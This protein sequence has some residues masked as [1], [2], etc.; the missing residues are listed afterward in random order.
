MIRQFLTALCLLG[1]LGGCGDA[2]RKMF[3]AS[4][5]ALAGEPMPEG[6]MRAADEKAEAPAAPPMAGAAPK[7][8]PAD[9]QAADADATLQPLR[10]MRMNT[11]QIIKGTSGEQSKAAPTRSWFPESFLFDPL[12]VTD[13]QGQATLDV[14]VPDRLTSWRI[15]ALAHSK[16]GSQAGATVSF[17][18]TL[19]AYVD[20]VVPPFLIAGDAVRLPIQL[21]NTTASAVSLPLQVDA[22]G[23]LLSGANGKVTVPASGSRVE[24]AELHASAPGEI[25]L[26]ASFGDADAIS[27]TIPV[28][29][30]GSP[31]SQLRGGTLAAARTL[32]IS[33][34]PDLLPGTAKVRLLVFPGALGVLRSELSS[35][36]S[37]GGSASDAY[38]LL[39]AGRAPQL[40]SALGDS[41]D[42]EAIRNLSIVASQRVL[43]D[44]RTPD[45]SVAAML[46]EA[47]LAQPG[48]PVMQRLAERLVAQVAQSQRP[49]GTFEGGDGW[50]LQRLLVVTAECVQVVR[51]DAQT[52]QAKQRAQSVSLL[53]SGAFER[54][55][56]RISDGYTA[57]A[58]LASGALPE[59]LRPKLLAKVR[60]AV[61]ERPDGSRVLPVERHVVRF[62]GLA[63]SEIEAT[64]L[65]ALALEG[66]AQA[67]WRADLGS[68]LLGSYSPATGWG[69]GIT[70]L[71]ALRAV[72][73]LF[74]TPLPASVAITLTMDGKP[75]AQ[76]ELAGAKLRDTLALD[77]ALADASGPHTFAVQATPA[78]PGLGF[79]LALTGYVPW[80]PEAMHGGLELQIQVAPEGRVGEPLTVELTANAPA[81]TPVRIR[82]ALP[83][84][85]QPE[86]HSLD[87]LIAAGTLSAYHA[88]PGVLVLEVPAQPANTPVH[89]VY[90]VIPTL[91]GTLHAQASTIEAVGRG[92]TYHLP[93][94]A[95]AVR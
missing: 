31:V 35:A 83:A 40:L 1:L 14:P 20:P 46:A 11:I 91:A 53:A 36:G 17:L 75:L 22:V 38:A 64:A 60:E 65:A 28:Q 63:P 12:L 47:G 19:P 45:V 73:A 55:L 93:P 72:L 48:N 15:L 44:A 13:A 26:H 82:Q 94:Q 37:R 50:T 27:R 2:P 92:D 49:D 34:A 29:P 88:E 33:G 57:A 9:G 70:N 87:A 30:S 18:G 23:G 56:D 7:P 85:V 21:V 76:G 8:S 6:S 68:A 4:A 42:P 51:Q 52:E 79:S 32:E 58:V 59:S 5:N 62:D 43:R 89:A 41:A 90:R 3:G 86:T 54:N 77:A 16:Q 61:K 71:V 84:G 10:K 39:L 24:F 69:D 80:K 81:N 74:K 78:V 95:W 25:S 66:D 67:P